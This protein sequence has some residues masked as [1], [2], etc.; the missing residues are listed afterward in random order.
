[1]SSRGQ[2][3]QISILPLAL[4]EFSQYWDQQVI[5]LCK[6]LYNPQ[7]SVNRKSN[8]SFEFIQCLIPFT[9]ERKRMDAELRGFLIQREI[10]EEFIQKLE[11]EKVS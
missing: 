2:Q 11:N 4:Y 3:L 7:F 1:M 10:D 5:L 9:Q 6:I 8:A